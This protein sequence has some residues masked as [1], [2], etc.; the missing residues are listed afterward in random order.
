MVAI[1]R[2]V[3]VRSSWKATL[4]R[5]LA[6]VVICALFLGQFL[7]IG[8]LNHVRNLPHQGNWVAHTVLAV[9]AQVVYAKQ[10]LFPATFKLIY[11]FM[12]V[13]AWWDLRLLAGIAFFGVVALAVYFWRG[14]PLR[15][16]CLAFYFACLLPVSN[17][18][19]FPAVMA[20]RYLYAATVGTCLLIALLLDSTRGRF[21]NTV[22]GLTV[23]TLASTTALRSAI[24]QDGEALWQ[25]GD[26]DPV[27]MED[28]EFPAAQVHYLRYLGAKDD[29]T[30]IL[31]LER[32]LA[33]RGIK[34]DNFGFT[35]E[36]LLNGARLLETTGNHAQAQRWVQLATKA[37]G[38]HP[39]MWS[40]MLT[41]TVH[42]NPS[43]AAV[44]AQRWSRIEPTPITNLFRV[45]TQL[46]LRDEVPRRQ[47]LLELV[48]AS[49]A[50]L[51][52]TLRAWFNE[53]GVNARDRFAEAVASCPH[54][55]PGPT[56]TQ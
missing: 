37:C 47:E 51:C 32:M 55:D 45:L 31:T 20:D 33:S 30:R 16:F 1:E 49:P 40:T 42:R 54:A 22:M 29:T 48:L 7:E 35:C 3:G 23:V 36:G 26:E 52:P 6:P 11:C 46:E 9:W 24:W 10:A 53:V 27:C 43:T 38:A 4:Q 28:P 19:P 15:L 50:E 13:D 44:A 25:D 34:D 17:L 41:V 12:P 14:A 8:R 56:P 2:W 39:K 5:L 18:V 21:K